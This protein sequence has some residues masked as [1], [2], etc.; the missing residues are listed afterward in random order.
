MVAGVGGSLPVTTGP[1]VSSQ[2]TVEGP[3]SVPM[4]DSVSVALWT[5]T[6]T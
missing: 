1:L 6:D 5:D 2:A 3:H 4:E